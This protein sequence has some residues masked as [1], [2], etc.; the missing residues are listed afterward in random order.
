MMNQRSIGADFTAALF[1]GALSWAIGMVAFSCTEILTNSFLD[2]FQPWSVWSVVLLTYAIFGALLGLGAGFG[3]WFLRV[4]TGWRGTSA[5]PLLMG[6]YIGVFLLMVIG[7]PLNGRYLP[8]FFAPISLGTN[9]LVIAACAVLALTIYAHLRSRAGVALW[10]SFINVSTA[11][12]LFTALGRYMDMYIVQT[13]PVSTALASFAAALVVCVMLWWCGTRILAMFTGEGNVA[14]AAGALVVGL[15]LIWGVS[16][17]LARDVQPY[18][19]S[20][21][22]A[23]GKPNLLWII[24]DTTRADHVGIY[25]Y[26]KGTTPG[27]DKLGESGVVFEKA[28]SQASWTMPSHF[29]MVTSR[30]DSGKDNALSADYETVAEIFRDEGYE[31]ASVLGN[32]S[33]GRR[34]G[35]DQGFA[36]VMDGPVNIFYLKFFDKLPVVKMLVKS[37]LLAPDTAVRWY[38]RHTFLEGVG[39]RGKDLTDRSLEWIEGLDGDRPFFLF[40][41]YMDVHDAFDPPEPFRQRFAPDVAPMRGFVRFDLEEGEAIDSNTFVRDKLPLMDDADWAEIVALYD[42]ELAYLDSHIGRMMDRLEALGVLDDTIVVITA[43]HGE[44]FGEH[45]LAYHFKALS[46]EETHVPLIIR[47]PAGLPSG[48][49]VPEPVELNDILPTVLELAGIES[50]APMDGK[51]LV[52]AARTGKADDEA[53]FTYLLRDPRAAFA[54]TQAGHLLGIRKDGQKYV[55]SSGGEHEFYELEGDPKAHDNR[56]LAAGAPVELE[57]EL[58]SWRARVGLEEIKKEK[59]DPVTRDRLRALGYID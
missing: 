13:E 33:L 36:D 44:L 7:V 56:F 2:L 39:A 28:I 3:I 31:T 37:G 21:S 59:L 54:H 16:S 14:S 29:Q 5:V 42:G 34:S 10:L 45:G 58:E 50:S 35:F 12:G 9:A 53:V 43:D 20:A 6:A 23:S 17:T 51:S 52:A 26:D 15:A 30:F 1:F 22:Q 25:G 55:W 11:F 49:R 57:E 19:A 46:E 18:G 48:Q 38:H 41:N 24:M 40:V 32:Y 47:Y 4:I 8:G 27:V